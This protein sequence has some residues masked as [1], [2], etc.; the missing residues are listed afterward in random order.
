MFSK[1]VK[2]LCTVKVT[3][4]H[5]SARICRPSFHENKPK[6]LVFSHTNKRFGLV[7]AKTG[8]IISGTGQTLKKVFCANKVEPTGAYTAHTVP[9]M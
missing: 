9:T 7:F 6:T 3:F 2:A 1:R 4:L 8:S 5:S